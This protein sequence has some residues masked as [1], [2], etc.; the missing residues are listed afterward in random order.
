MMKKL[1]KISLN[2]RNRLEINK[3][4]VEKELIR[5]ELEAEKLKVEAKF[6]IF[7]VY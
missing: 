7:N 2:N 4:R 6:N 3:S 5:R 1:K